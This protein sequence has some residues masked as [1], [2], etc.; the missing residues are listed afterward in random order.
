[1]IT[2]N[3]VPKDAKFRI[4][5]HLDYQLKGTQAPPNFGK[6]P[7]PYGPFDSTILVAGG[8]SYSS[9]TL[10]GR[11]K[12]VTVV[13]GRMTDPAGDAIAD[14]TIRLTQNGNTAT[15]VTDG[16]G[17]YLFYDGQACTVA[18]GLAGGCTGASTTSR[19]RALD[20]S[21]RSNA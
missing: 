12:K 11:G 16:E 17:N 6:Q 13:Y 9:T 19:A 3:G 20:T 4:N 2:L 5:V 21:P 1:M 18:D 8:S 14:V 7:I 15:A 10:V